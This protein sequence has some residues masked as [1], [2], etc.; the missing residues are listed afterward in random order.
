MM[1]HQ[2]IEVTVIVYEDA[3]KERMNEDAKTDEDWKS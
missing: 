2:F 3:L 1:S